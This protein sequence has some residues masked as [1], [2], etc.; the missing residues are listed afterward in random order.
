[1]LVRP[2]LETTYVLWPTFHLP[3]FLSTLASLKTCQD[4]EFFALLLAI[5]YM[6]LRERRTRKDLSEDTGMQ[7]AELC[8]PISY[9]RKATDN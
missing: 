4:P 5:A 1:M 2:F 3:T 9:L 8:K 6:A 7:F